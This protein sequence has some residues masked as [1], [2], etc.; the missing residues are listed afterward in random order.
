MLKLDILRDGSCSLI[1]TVSSLTKGMDFDESEGT[2]CFAT[3]P[4]LRENLNLSELLFPSSTMESSAEITSLRPEKDLFGD[5]VER[6]L[7][8]GTEETPVREESS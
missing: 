7:E 4:A 2:A 5:L 6:D 3:L 8:G 1:S